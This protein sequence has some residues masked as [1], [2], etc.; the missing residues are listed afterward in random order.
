MSGSLWDHFG[1]TL[2]S[3]LDHFGVIFGS[4]WD[5]F[6]VIFWSFWDHSKNIFQIFPNHFPDIFE[7]SPKKY[8]LTVTHGIFFK[9]FL[10]IIL[11]LI[12]DLKNLSKTRDLDLFFHCEKR[13]FLTLRIQNAGQIRMASRRNVKIYEKLEKTLFFS[14]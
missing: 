3:F 13:W 10:N 4:L 7:A 8:F 12:F 6:G 1:M 14:L 5:H 11:Q 9:L 2:G